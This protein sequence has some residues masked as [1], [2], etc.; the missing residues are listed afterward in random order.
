MSIC[1]ASHTEVL[2]GLSRVPAPR[3][4]AEMS[5]KFPPS[6]CSQISAGAHTQIIGEPI[7]TDEVKVL[8][9]QKRHPS[10]IE[11]NQSFALDKNVGS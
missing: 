2:R 1:I 4:S 3:M 8:T 11:C 7:S 10:L 9:G 5:S 6:P